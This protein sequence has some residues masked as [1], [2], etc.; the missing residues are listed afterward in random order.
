MP[1]ACWQYVQHR[2][3]KEQ[4]FEGLCLVLQQNPSLLL[5]TDGRV[6]TFEAFAF[7]LASW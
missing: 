5:D 7:A 4:S 1:V 3:E 6:D 2:G